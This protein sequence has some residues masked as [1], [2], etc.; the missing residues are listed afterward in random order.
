LILGTH[1]GVIV[2][3]RAAAGDAGSQHL[4]LGRF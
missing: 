1:P 3:T 4:F 2:V